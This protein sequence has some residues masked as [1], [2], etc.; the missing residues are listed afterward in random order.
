MS[1]MLKKP[2]K[3]TLW[4][5]RNKII[6]DNQDNVQNEYLEEVCIATIGSDTMDSPIRAFNQI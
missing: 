5:D 4:E 6:Y 3:I 2:Y 1:E